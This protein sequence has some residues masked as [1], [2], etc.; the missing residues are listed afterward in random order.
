[1]SRRDLVA[2][3]ALALVAAG[4]LWLVS[5][6]SGNAGMTLYQGNGPDAHGIGVRYPGASGTNALVWVPCDMPAR[7]PRGHAYSTQQLDATALYAMHRD[8][9]RPRYPYCT[10]LPHDTMID[11]FRVVHGDT[12]E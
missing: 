11:G 8:C 7:H 6:V 10:G 12:N 5:A 9:V 1:M 3:T 4:V 2:W